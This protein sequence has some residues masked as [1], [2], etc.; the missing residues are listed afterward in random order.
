MSEF[1]YRKGE[2]IPLNVAHFRTDIGMELPI[3]VGADLI[4]KFAYDTGQIV[5][6][7]S[8]NPSETEGSVL[9]CDLTGITDAHITPYSS[10]SGLNRA[11]IIGWGGSCRV[12]LP[13]PI[14]AS[15]RDI[16]VAVK[17]TLPWDDMITDVRDHGALGDGVTDDTDAFL[18]AIA[19]S[20]GRAVIVPSGNYRVN[21][22]FSCGNGRK[23]D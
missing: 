7:A 17:K 1:H 11:T 19:G 15:Q 18:K 21:A 16:D 3:K 20:K 10:I 6:D 22:T 8:G 13:N 23:D 2:T 5:F 14:E 12:M 9:V 4:V